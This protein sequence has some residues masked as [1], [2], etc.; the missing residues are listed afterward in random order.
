[1]CAIFNNIQNGARR[2]PVEKLIKI[3][4][5]ILLLGTVFAW[6]NF[7][8]ELFSWLRNS[9][10][11]LGCSVSANPF[12]SPCFYGALFFLA[13]FVLNLMILKASRQAR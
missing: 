9:S 2:L 4:S 7:A 3:Q 1:M 10:C 13:A 8:F 12:F 6:T 11:A 5:A